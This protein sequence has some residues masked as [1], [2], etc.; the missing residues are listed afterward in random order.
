MKR[1]KRH[2]C[3]FLSYGKYCCHKDNPLK[4]GKLNLALCEYNSLKKCHYLKYSKIIDSE[5]LERLREVLQDEPGV[6][7]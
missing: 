7:K 3:P 1:K 4:E 6:K 2:N 5:G